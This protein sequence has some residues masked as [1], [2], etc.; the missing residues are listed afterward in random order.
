MVMCSLFN[1]AEYVFCWIG[2]QKTGGIF[3][4]IN[5]RLAEGK[6]ALHI[7][8]SEPKVFIFDSDMRDIVEKA[9]RFSRHKPERLVMVG[10]GELFEGVVSYGDFVE[11]QSWEDIFPSDTGPFT[12]ILRLYTSGTTGAPKGVPLNSVN[13]LMRSYDVI[14]H[15]PLNPLDKTMNM[16]PWFHAG[17]C[18]AA[19]LVPACMPVRNSW[20]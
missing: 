11:G 1:T 6:I 15:F 7:E 8:D 9:V 14:M 13:N 20:P 5:F 2:V 4:P 17:G 16:T 10:E 3:A 12:E 19:D 18:T